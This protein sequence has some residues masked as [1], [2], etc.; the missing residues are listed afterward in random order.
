LINIRSSER[1]N[2][3]MEVYKR[4]IPLENLLKKQVKIL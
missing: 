3:R 1:F 2:E 4:K